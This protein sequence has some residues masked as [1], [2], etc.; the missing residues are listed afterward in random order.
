VLELRVAGPAVSYNEWVQLSFTS[1]SDQ[2][3]ANI[4][5]PTASPTGDK[6]SNLMR[7]AF[8]MAPDETSL[9]KMPFFVFEDGVPLYGFRFDPGKTDISC[10]VEASSSL[11]NWSRSLFDSTIDSLNFRDGEWVLMYDLD[12]DPAIDSNQFYRLR[13]LLNEQ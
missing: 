11:T 2:T 12:L 7:Y 8:D 13:L 3:N 1:P 4:S 10:Q 9:D 6:T 5:G